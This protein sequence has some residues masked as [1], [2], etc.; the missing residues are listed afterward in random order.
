MSIS[1]ERAGLQTLLHSVLSCRCPVNEAIEHALFE[2]YAALDNREVIDF[3]A[4]VQ[5]ADA[6]PVAT[7]VHFLRDFC[8]YLQDDPSRFTI[9]H[10]DVLRYFSTTY[11]LNRMKNLN[12]LLVREPATYLFSHMLVPVTVSVEAGSAEAGCIFND[13]VIRFKNIFV[14]AEF[15]L[16]DDLQYGL[17]MGTVVTTLSPQQVAMIASHLNLFDEIPFLASQVTLVDFSDFQHY[18]D[19]RADVAA[20]YARHF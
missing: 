7:P 1:I 19:Y 17:H 11:H 2:A 4:I 10:N 12:P 15:S 8:V 3:N 14:S 20:R 5:I 18:G 9:T 6:N 16:I 13:T